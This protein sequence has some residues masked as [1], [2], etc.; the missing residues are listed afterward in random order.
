M[1]HTART[2]PDVQE[3]QEAI[4]DARLRWRG[5]EVAV[6]FLKTV[7]YILAVTLGFFAADNFLALPAGAR[8]AALV[9][10]AAGLLYMLARHVLL[11][12]VSQTTDEMVAARAEK[13]HPELDNRLI[14]AVLF[15]KEQPGDELGR[16]MTA[17]QMQ[18]TAEKLR[19]TPLD[20]LV[21]PRAVWKPIK[22]VIILCAV[23]AAY[24][25][26]L[27]GHFTNAFHRYAR[28]TSFV[29]PVSSVRL[30][31]KPGDTQVLQ[32]ESL[33][34]SATTKGRLPSSAQ[35]KVLLPDGTTET[36]SMSFQG[37]SFH[38]TFSNLQKPLDYRVEAGGGTSPNY[39]IEVRQ[40][41]V[42]QKVEVTRSY[43]DYT[44]LQDEEMRLENS[45]LAAPKGTQVTLNIT[46]D[47]P[48]QTGVL[49]LRRTSS[50][51]D[52]ES[53]TENVRLSGAS[54]SSLSGHFTLEYSGNFWIKVRDREG[55]PNEPNMRRM[56]AKPDKPPTVSV[57]EPGK[58]V[59]VAPSGSVSVIG[60]AR[61]DIGLSR[62]ALQVQPKAGGSWQDFAAWQADPGR[63]RMRQ[64]AVLKPAEL[65]LTKGDTLLYRLQAAD[66]RP[67]REPVNSKTYR[68]QVSGPSE[69]EQTGDERSEELTELVKKL[70]ERQETNLQETRSLAE[71][72]GQTDPD[73][74]EELLRRAEDL[75]ATQKGI[76]FSAREGSQMDSSPTAKVLG[77]LVEGELSTAVDH[78]EDLQA[79]EEPAALADGTRNAAGIQ[80]KVLE[81]LR[82]LLSNPQE[83]AAERLDE[84][85]ASERASK[86]NEALT[87]QRE[88]AEKMVERL[89]NF[90]QDQ[91]EAV[92]MMSRLNDLPAENFTEEDDETLNNVTEMEEEWAEFFREKATDLSQLNQQ[93]FSIATQADEFLEIHSEVQ[94]ALEAAKKKE[95][96]I[97]VPHARAAKQMAEEITTNLEKWLPTEP[98]ST[99]WNMES[100]MDDYN[101]PMVELPDQLQD[102]VGELIE[103]QSELNEQAEDLTSNAMMSGGEKGLGWK[104][105]DG[106]ISSMGAKGVTGNRLPDSHEVGGRSGEGRTGKSSGQFVEKKATGKGGRKTP[107]RLTKDPFE[108]GTVK[109]TSKRP[110]TGSTGGGKKSGWGAEGLQ[111]APPSVQ[112]KLKRIARRQRQLLDKARRLNHGLK[113]YRYPR[114]RLPRTIK[115][116]KGMQ[117]NLQKAELRPY[118]ARSKRVTGDLKDVQELVR[119]QKQVQRDRA[120]NMPED[121]RQEIS[122]AS[123]GKVP[124]EYEG[125]V[126]DY[127]RALAASEKSKGGSG[128]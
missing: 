107:T 106:P 99:K 101:M 61:D 117:N 79:A 102:L 4:D 108:S 80:E 7:L 71:R 68:V 95:T 74:M 5:T 2:D 50:T 125:L 9:L 81:L 57:L 24:G 91:E 83:L 96:E 3:L 36:R 32:G 11:P 17:E 26:F 16:R 85:S 63:K 82:R 20:K 90:R 12:A 55:T 110:A 87:R 119:K 10:G 30:Q 6:G 62:M 124:H 22:Y 128:K 53:E 100:T 58:E 39:A 78:L 115:L 66:E 118:A 44:G 72:T 69:G 113:K 123:G 41:P 121:I 46:A 126:K 98:D 34:V 40:R 35:L 84:D 93:D 76:R 77:N 25:I 105:E 86:E 15:K 19:Q 65:E 70:I 33:E 54:G 67:G 73:G 8:L 75:A 43:P 112:Q 88:Q 23:L 64:G 94:K 89:K 49:K 31:V 92:E 1:S 111:G 104:A 18:R 28:P 127:F 114:G 56:V 21:Q 45:P 38:Y 42:I 120:G 60:E 59:S 103:E 51:S 29:P 37:G 47:K 116:M 52:Q 14:N 109:D 27:P 97:A 122:S 13:A 48:L